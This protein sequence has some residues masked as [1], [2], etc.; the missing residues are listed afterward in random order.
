MRWLFEYLK[1]AITYRD[2]EI[3]ELRAQVKRYKDMLDGIKY[4]MDN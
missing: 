1:W 4:I 2:R 3:I